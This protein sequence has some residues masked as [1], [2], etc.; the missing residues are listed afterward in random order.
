MTETQNTRSAESVRT[1][2]TAEDLQQTSFEV[3]EDKIRVHA[4]NL[5]AKLDGIIY[6]W[7]GGFGS[8]ITSRERGLK[9]GSA[10]VIGNVVFKAYRVDKFANPFARPIVCWC[11]Q[12]SIDGPWL[13]TFKR[14]FFAISKI[15]KTP[16]AVID[17]IWELREFVSGKKRDQK[18]VPPYSLVSWLQQEVLNRIAGLEKDAVTQHEH[19]QKLEKENIELKKRLQQSQAHERLVPS[20]LRNLLYAMQKKMRR[21]DST[22]TPYENIQQHA[23]C[24]LSELI[25]RVD[26]SKQDAETQRKRIQE[27]EKRNVELRVQ[28]HIAT[29]QRERLREFTH[30]APAVESSWEKRNPEPTTDNEQRSNRRYAHHLA[31]A[32]RE[33]RK[34]Q[35]TVT[36]LRNDLLDAQKQLQQAQA[37]GFKF[38]AGEEYEITIGVD[39]ANKS[40]GHEPAS[41]LNELAAD[42]LPVM[43]K[44]WK[45]A[46]ADLFV[47]E[48]E[49]KYSPAYSRPLTKTELLTKA[50][51]MQTH[52]T[53]DARNQSWC[54][55]DPGSVSGGFGDSIG[56]GS[57]AQID[58]ADDKRHDPTR[59][60]GS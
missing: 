29:E 27:L 32:I 36:T 41:S 3:P 47:D 43:H 24:V 22:E 57:T 49:A 7:G 6:R 38:E 10:R 56:H 34:L 59:P 40:S 54:S 46:Y 26:G 53:D 5:S 35:D 25:Q 8:V 51:A 20:T 23:A 14:R 15:P 33:K 44:G 60:S 45:K 11:P 37:R 9:E 30:T 19:I 42:E 52:R 1:N 4:T 18:Q 2:P 58:E 12:Q 55:S 48:T 16:E 50:K 17:V 28:L 39:L 13:E 21:G 31:E